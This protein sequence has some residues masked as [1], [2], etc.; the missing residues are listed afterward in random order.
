[1]DQKTIAI[2]SIYPP[3][4]TLHGSGASGVGSYTKNLLTNMDEHER[5]KIVVLCDYDTEPA[6][7][8]EDRMMIERCRQRKGIVQWLQQIIRVLEK[9]P[10]LT[11]IHIQHEFNM[12]GSILTVPVFL[13]LLRI[14]RKYKIVVTYHGVIDTSSIDKEY[15]KINSL[16]RYFPPFFLK[17]AFWFFY[18]VSSKH[19][20]T[21]IV[22]EEYFKKVLMKYRYRD[23][24]VK[25]IVHGVEDRNLSISQHDARSKLGIES[26]KK[27]LLYFGFLA[28]YKGVD[29]LLN[30]FQTMD[31]S[32][33][34]LILAGGTPKRTLADPLFRARYEGV[35]TK[36]KNMTGI[37]RMGFVPDEEIETLYAAADVLVIPYLY[38]LAASGPMA[39]AITYNLPF[40]V[41]DVFS[42]VI[43]EESMRFEKTPQ[44]LSKCITQFFENPQKIQNIIITM[45]K[46][47]LWKVVSEKTALLYT[48]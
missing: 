40:I 45:R 27:V 3:Q 13:M 14:L 18:A 46:E 23:E 10:H 35:D 2:I 7:Y 17:F 16:P 41:S 38:M 12:F 31:Y 37:T 19:I 43:V 36:A 22:H 5:K 32:Q 39:L 15:G 9:Y 42:P 11:T 20:D 1:M 28:G 4:A 47:R 21:A 8:T 24:Q 34:H 33:Y 6:S 29:L 44:G 26:D 48:K 30:T 25:V